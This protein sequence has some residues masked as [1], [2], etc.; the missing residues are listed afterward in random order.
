MTDLLIRNVDPDLKRRI[1]ESAREH[2]RSLSDE[3][4]AL[5]RTACSTQTDNRKLGTL[6]ANLLEP[7]YRGDDLVF[8]VKDEPINPPPG[9]E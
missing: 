6:M 4:K 2:N 1:E 9:F 8:E 7:E 3:I 5:L